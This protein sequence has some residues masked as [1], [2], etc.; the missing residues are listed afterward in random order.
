MRKIQLDVIVEIVQVK[1][2]VSEGSAQHS[3]GFAQPVGI[4]VSRKRFAHSFHELVVK[5]FKHSASFATNFDDDSVR[6]DFGH[7]NIFPVEWFVVS[8]VADQAGNV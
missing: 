8:I 1:N 6:V 2:E 3:K 4:R 5:D 7:N